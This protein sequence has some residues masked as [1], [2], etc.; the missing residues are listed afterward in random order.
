[1]YNEHIQFLRG[2]DMNTYDTLIIGSGYSPVGYALTNKNCLIVEETQ[3]C[4]THFYLALKSFLHN[5]Y[6]PVTELGKN[7]MSFF[8]KYNLFGDGY[9]LTN[10][11]E[12]AFCDFLSEQNINIFLKCRVVSKF[13]QDDGTYKVTLHSNEGHSTIIAKKIIDTTL[14]SKDYENYYTVLYLTENADSAKSVLTEA[15]PIS[16]PSQI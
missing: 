12:A 9:M 10:A 16:F 6:S 13:L 14:I 4:D 2:I 11:L 7:L 3:C 5:E 8:E 1:M 15:F